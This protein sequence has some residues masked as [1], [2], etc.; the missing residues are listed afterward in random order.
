MQVQSKC[1]GILVR[2]DTCL[3]S[4]PR[5]R[6]MR[7][8]ILLGSQETTMVGAIGSYFD[9][10]SVSEGIHEPRSA[11]EEICSVGVPSVCEG[12]IVDIEVDSR[13]EVT[14]LPASIGVDTC[15]LHETRF[16]MCEGHHVAAGG[17]KL[18]ELSDRILGLEVGDVR[19]GV[20]NLLVR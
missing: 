11:G 15:P 20:V 9:H 8:K 1:V 16:S 10:G 19:G 3:P 6:S 2:V 14:S 13:A 7:W 17:G 5:R 18:H 4:V 12:E